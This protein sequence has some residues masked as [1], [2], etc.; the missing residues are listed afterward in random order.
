MPTPS[1][2]APPPVPADVLRHLFETAPLMM[3]VVGLRADDILHVAD[4]PAAAAFFGTTPDATSGRLAS[5]LGVPPEHLERWLHHYRACAEADGPVRFRYPHETPEGTRWLEAVVSPAGDDDEHYSY[6]VEEVTDRVA[7]E[8]EI[9]ER[10]AREG[11]LLRALPDLLFRLDRDGRYLQ[12]HTP[13]PDALAAPADELVGRTLHD[14]IPPDLADRFLGAIGRALDSGDPEEVEY[15]LVTSDGVERTFEARVSPDPDRG[16]VLVIVRDLTDWH[17]DRRALDETAQRLTTLIQNIQGGVI[18]EDAN[19]Q[20]L[21]ANER[22]CEIFGIDAP[23]D[24]L[25]GGDC[26][27]A[28]ERALPMF[29]EP[30]A[31]RARVEAT[32]RDGAQVFAE[33]VDFADGRTFERDY[34]P[35]TLGDGQVGHLWLY[36]DV[37]ERVAATRRLRSREARYRLLAENMQD[38]V[39]LHN[40]DGTYEWVSPS[41]TTLLGY[42]PDE[43][44]GTNP[45]DLIHPDDT[46]A[47]R[48][49]SHRPALQNEDDVSVVVRVRHRDR[50]YVWLETLTKPIVDESGAVVRLQ[51][52]SRDVTDRVEMEERLYH[53]AYHDALTDLPNRAL[54]SVRLEEVIAR[55]DLSDGFAVLFLDLDRF[56]VVNDT[57]GHTAGDRLLQV[58]G[59]RLRAVIRDG[60]MVAR[61]GGDEFAV[62]LDGLPAP[63]YAENVAARVIDDLAAP[64]DIDGRRLYAGA[65]L[66]VVVGRPD[67]D[68][69]DALLGEADLAMYE[70]KAEGRGG[71]AIYSE[72]VHAEVTHK[73]RLEMDLRQAVERDELRLLF[74]PIV[75]L[76]DGALTGF[77]AL[78]RWEHPDLG[79]LPPIAFLGPAEESGQLTAVD[80]WVLVEACRVAATWAD[81]RGANR[82]SLQLNVNCSGRD[83]LTDAFTEDVLAAVARHGIR[84]GALSLEITEQVL[85]DDPESVSAALRRLQSGG[86]GFSLDDFGT[87]YSSLS[88]LHNLPVDCVKV[89]RSFVADMM[90]RDQSHK[91]V[92]TVVHLGRI[93]EKSV[94]AEGI[95][96]AD[97]LG[98][99]QAVGCAFGQGYLFDRPLSV[100]AAFALATADVLPWHTYWL[101]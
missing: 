70:A 1:A 42:A 4:N 11:T 14:A 76:S 96:D 93:L 30:E 95:E 60:D 28:L 57:L 71:V 53:Q 67:H 92:E 69:P 39:A 31:A 10:A 2:P 72:A 52:S 89:D 23:P 82:P 77:E 29:A 99:L 19:R 63:G 94:V 5:D 37:S 64:V 54:F 98:A 90:A 83:L 50:R 65:S 75:R 15:D 13:D 41:V 51:T 48:T 40:P 17:A 45:Y 84:P 35:V 21:L 47:V 80:R 81:A 58:V 87:G 18:F 78:V 66:G 38:L 59:D 7:Q 97:Q 20:L 44:V 68:T 33:P 85:V 6:W 62:L 73:L 74:Q 34:V 101:P 86:V 26:V 22:F 8:S 12:V 24:A 43:L 25:V 79:L 91:L 3:G 16:E 32:L 55:Y 61:I 9:R 100:E 46:V 56:K 27:A 36:H 88:T 49:G